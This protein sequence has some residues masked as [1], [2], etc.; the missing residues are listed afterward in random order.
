MSDPEPTVYILLSTYNGEAYLASLLESLD[1]QRSADLRII[2]R[3]DGSTDRTRDILTSWA[4]GRANRQI[5]LGSN[6][7]ACRS[8]FAL[9]D[10]VPDGSTVFFADQDDIWHPDKVEAGLASLSGVGPDTAGLY[11]SRLELVDT[12]GR[13]Q[14]LSPLWLRPPSFENALVENIAT[15]CT[16]AINPAALALLKRARG[17]HAIMHDWWAYLVVSAFG[18]VIYDPIPRI[19]YRVHEANSVGLPRNRLEWFVSRVRRQWSDRFVTRILAQA[20]EFHELLGEKLD[21]VRL[22]GLQALL[23]TKS[24]SGRMRF[25]LQNRVER[26]SRADAIAFKFLVLSH[27]PSD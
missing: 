20:E 18:K 14:G 15:G 19:K 3:D 17:Q 25:L 8:F 4:N 24:L 13:H 16:I 11:C 23:E 21:P 5:Y 2:V 22:T 12:D 7:G 26:Q 6:L 9:L 10:L 27:R 1:R